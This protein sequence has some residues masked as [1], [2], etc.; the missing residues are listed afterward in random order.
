WG[1]L[2]SNLFKAARAKGVTKLIEPHFD[3]ALRAERFQPSA[4]MMYGYMLP[5]QKRHH[6]AAD[7]YARALAVRPTDAR[8]RYYRAVALAND[9]EKKDASAEFDL[10]ERHAKEDPEGRANDIIQMIHF[11]RFRMDHPSDE[12]KFQDARKLVFDNDPRKSPES[13][14]KD[15]EK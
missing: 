12:S 15:L 4:V 13:V 9:G 6:R 11:E 2:Y 1:L 14:R 3:A 8:I 10:A 7:V 5:D